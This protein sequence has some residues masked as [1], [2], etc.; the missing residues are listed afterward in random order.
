MKRIK[1]SFPYE[2]KKMIVEKAESGQYSITQIARDHE[3]S[4]S[5]IGLWRKKLQAG[6]IQREPSYREKQ[7]EAELEVYKKK[8]GELTVAVDVIKK[9]LSTLPSVRR[10][11]L[12]VESP[13][14]LAVSGPLVK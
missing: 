13:R 3:I 10:L 7:L 8:V 4:P 6:E 9:H 1:R 2:F 14:T 5:L 11:N 12:S